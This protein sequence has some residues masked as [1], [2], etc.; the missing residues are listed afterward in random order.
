MGKRIAVSTLSTVVEKA[1]AVS[2]LQ[3]QLDH[4]D[5]LKRSE[6]SS[7]DF[8]K[9]RRDTSVAIEKIFGIDSKH[10]R[11][12]N[13][14]RYHSPVW[15]TGTP[16]H[17][18]HKWYVD[19]LNIAAQ[20]LR[21]MIDEVNE[22]HADTSSN[23]PHEPVS[24]VRHICSRFHLVARQLLSRR[25]R[26]TTLAITDEYDVQDLL[27]SL[28]RIDFDDVRSEEWTP[29]YAA[30]SSRMD[31]LLKEHAIIVETKKT[32]GRLGQKEI[33]DQIIIDISRYRSHPD[34]KTLICLIYDPENYIA[35]PRGIEADLSKNH[36]GLETIVIVSPK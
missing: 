10:S 3:R 25:E 4:I 20:I 12:F 16:D 26:R 5:V 1:T 9:W 18:F 30:K 32:S 34:C 11:E 2:R 7:G 28:L 8:T 29:S 35:N 24:R 23:L 22:Y 15:T 14:V 17:V 33:A 21:S 6:A 19:G 31:F 27:H 13:D 36:D